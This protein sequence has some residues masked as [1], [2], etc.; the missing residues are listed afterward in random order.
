MKLLREHSVKVSFSQV[1][2]SFSQTRISE[3]VE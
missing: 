1:L 3:V 2:A